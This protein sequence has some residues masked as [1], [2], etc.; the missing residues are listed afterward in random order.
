LSFW[1]RTLGKMVRGNVV[2]IYCIENIYTHRKY[3][4]QSKNIENRWNGHISSIQNGLCGSLLQKDFRDYGINSFEFYV[5]ERCG[6]AEL[7]ELEHRYISMY[8][9][10]NQE[11][12]YNFLG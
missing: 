1:D 8:N 7:E 2:G 10:T 12:G 6:D 5:L 4:G 9:T 3:I 11:F